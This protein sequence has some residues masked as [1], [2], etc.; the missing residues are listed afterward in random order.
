VQ[1]CRRRC[2]FVACL[3]GTGWRVSPVARQRPSP[4]PST[5]LLHVHELAPTKYHGPSE[6][7]PSLCPRRGCGRGR[8][9]AQGRHSDRRLSGASSPPSGQG[10]PGNPPL[11]ITA[12]H[13]RSR[14]PFPTS[15]AP[16]LASISH[17]PVSANVSRLPPPNPPPPSP[18]HSLRRSSP[19][20]L[21]ETTD[22]DTDNLYILP[23]PALSC[24]LI[25]LLL[26]SLCSVSEGRRPPRT[27]AGHREQSSSHK[28]RTGAL[29]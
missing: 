1:P 26:H 4:E 28:P 8:R 3:T 25:L 29:L 23:P 15:P 21:Q 12:R 2:C 19:L 24:S 20:L 16:G 14:S 17:R 18:R 5:R 13:G 10:R 7:Q 9:H 6:K 11:P 27:G 22:E